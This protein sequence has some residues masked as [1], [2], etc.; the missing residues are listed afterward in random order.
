MD[1]R[2][3]KIL[4]KVQKPARYSGGE[5]NQIIKDREKVDIRLAFCFPDT[6]EIGMSN[7]GMK[8]LYQT[9]NS[10]EFVWCE[11]AF[12]PW[13]DMYEEMKKGGFLFMRWSQGILLTALMP[14]PSQSAMRWPTQPFLT[15]SPLREFLFAAPKGKS[16]CP[17]FLQAEAELS[18]RR[19]CL[20]SWTFS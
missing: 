7:L 16:C 6:Y 2:I 12:A 14:L 10:L 8:I 15:C 9:M 20:P 13:E 3:E 19:P 4:P 18:I 1:K 11:R 5:Y 17:L